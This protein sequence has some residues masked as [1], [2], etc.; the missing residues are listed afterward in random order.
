MRREN[1]AG[2]NVK[3]SPGTQND[4]FAV[5]LFISEGKSQSSGDRPSCRVGP[6]HLKSGV[7][8]PNNIAS[9]AGPPVTAS[10]LPGLLDYIYS[11]FQ[12][13][14]TEQPPVWFLAVGRR[15]ALPRADALVSILLYT[16]VI[17][18]SGTRQQYAGKA[19]QGR[20]HSN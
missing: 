20:E 2:V 12:P 13:L 6:P 1:T 16:N 14:R 15:F 5:L 18:C 4:V 7:F 19:I 9:T 8:H 11:R 10:I 3:Q 17:V